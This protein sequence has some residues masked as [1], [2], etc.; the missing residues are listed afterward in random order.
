MNEIYFEVTFLVAIEQIISLSV[1]SLGEYSNCCNK[2]NAKGSN[3]AY[4]S[5][6]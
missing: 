4:R 5:N 1:C 2:K 6:S 3:E